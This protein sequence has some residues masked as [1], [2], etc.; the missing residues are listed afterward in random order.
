MSSIAS[1]FFPSLKICFCWCCHLWVCVSVCKGRY[2]ISKPRRCEKS[3]H[4]NNLSLWI[5]RSEFLPTVPLHTVP[6]MFSFSEI[7]YFMDAG[8][9]ARADQQSLIEKVIP[10]NRLA[11]MKTNMK[12]TWIVM[13]RFPLLTSDYYNYL[14]YIFF[15]HSHSFL[16]SS[17]FVRELRSRSSTSPKREG[18][19]L[20]ILLE[21]RDFDGVC[22]VTPIIWY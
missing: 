1:E 13:I 4:N 3:S 17:V 6:R 20:E 9:K 22:G 8:L 15:T 10:Q 5:L 7:T 14:F 19:N 2:G 12:S 11:E 18:E 21:I 16:N